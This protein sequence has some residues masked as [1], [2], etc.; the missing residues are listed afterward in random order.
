MKQ[1]SIIIL[2]S[3]FISCATVEQP[4]QTFTSF[5]ESAGSDS[6]LL[7]PGFLLKWY[8]P[9]TQ[10]DNLAVV[11]D[12]VEI[13][14]ITEPDTCYSDTC[15]YSYHDTGLI[16]GERYYYFIRGYYGDS[17][18]TSTT[19]SGMQYSFGFEP[20]I[21]LVKYESGNYTH[22]KIP[23]TNCITWKL[24]DLGKWGQRYMRQCE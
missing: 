1:I 4:Q 18:K 13:A 21:E 24:G 7:F 10:F 20:Y 17:T 19:I 14:I 8:V 12:S 11:R 22:I 16:E 9:G 5:F 15:W 23:N 3:C 2:L 6:L